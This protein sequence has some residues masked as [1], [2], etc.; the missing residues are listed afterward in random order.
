MMAMSLWSQMGFSYDPDA[1]AAGFEGFLM[2]I[3]DLENPPDVFSISYGMPEFA[4]YIPPAAGGPDPSVRT[5][6]D[7]AAMKLGLRGVTIV[8]SSGDDGAQGSIMRSGKISCAQLKDPAAA[9]DG[10]NPIGLRTP[11]PTYPNRVD[12]LDGVAVIGS[13]VVD[14]E[15]ASFSLPFTVHSISRNIIKC[16]HYIQTYDLRRTMYGFILYHISNECIPTRWMAS[17]R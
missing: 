7:N 6:F 3:M 8:V 10:K 2:D 11:T 4:I 1:T 17:F 16:L 5:T 15:F 12:I 13:D 9:F 14:L